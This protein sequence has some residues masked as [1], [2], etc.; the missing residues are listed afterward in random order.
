M[1]NVT[2]GR[3]ANGLHLRGPN[4]VIS[5]GDEGLAG[6]LRLAEYMLRG[7]ECRMVLAGGMGLY[8]GPEIQAPPGGEGRGAIRRMA[9]GTLLLA[10]TLEETARE[11]EFPILATLT[12]VEEAVE[13]THRVGELPVRFLGADGLLELTGA[14]TR[15]TV[16]HISWPTRRG[17]GSTSIR[18]VPRAASSR[19]NVVQAETSVIKEDEIRPPSS[20]SFFYTTT[21]LVDEPAPVHPRTGAKQKLLV[22]TDAET[23]YRHRE[24]LDWGGLPHRTVVCS[25]ATEIPGVLTL[26]PSDKA[27]VERLLDAPDLEGW[28]AVLAVQDHPDGSEE[29]ESPFDRLAAGRELLDLLFLV[30]KHGYQSIGEG[31]CKLGALLLN[32]ECR[33][34]PT[35]GLFAGLLKSLARELPRANVKTVVTDAAD[36]TEALAQMQTEWSTGPAPNRVEWVYQRGPR[37]RVALQ[38]LPALTG[39][40]H[41]WLTPDAVVLATGGGRGVTA[42]LVEALPRRHHCR[43][44]L[45]GRSDPKKVPSHLLSM[46]EAEFEA[47]EALFYKQ[48][49]ERRPGTRITDLK[50]RYQRYRNAREVH[51]TIEVLSDLA[52][53]VTYA[54]VDLLDREAVA[55]AMEAL[56]SRNGRLDLV[57]HGAGIQKSQKL[58]K[59]ELGEFRAIIDTKLVGLANLYREARARSLLRDTHFHLLT[60]VFSFLGNDGQ[61][62]Y[63][64]ANEALNALATQQSMAGGHGRWTSMAWLGWASIGMTRGS[65]YANLAISRNL[66]PVTAAEGQA[67]LLDLLA[68]TPVAAVNL[69]ISKG[70]LDF[71]GARLEEPSPDGARAAADWS[72]DAQNHPFLN[73]H[74][75]YGRPTMPGAFM[76][77]LAVRAALGLRPHMRANL[78]EDIAFLRFAKPPADRPLQ[79]R[80][81][82]E[83]VEET[84]E[85]VLVRVRL[86]SDFIHDSGRI[87][88]KDMIHFQADIRMSRESVAWSAREVQPQKPNEPD[89]YDPYLAA[90]SPVKLD[91]FFR[92]LSEIELSSTGRQAR[93][94]IYDGRKLEALAGMP[95]AAVLLDGLFR[96]SMIHRGSGGGFPIYVPIRCGRIFLAAN[97]N[98]LL[99]YRRG[100]PLLL[101][102]A[103]PHG[104]SEKMANPYVQVTDGDGKL[105]LMVTDLEAK[106]FG[107][108]PHYTK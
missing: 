10:L 13:P 37:R 51:Q 82:A 75:I 67:V 92:C 25:G 79:L 58:V 50:R 4:F 101:S 15:T 88:H 52:G 12:T 60:S 85:E 21:C 100:G 102:G 104:N 34:T 27:S 19:E 91:G 93:F 45:W 108:V 73:D 61:P 8:A 41:A 96:F 28:D 38:R 84:H 3:V 43:V 35:N 39:D 48:E 23:A 59:K 57:L 56:V 24:L 63:G 54:A 6:L 44:I 55:L 9:E 40:R 11:R 30:A 62:D 18:V 95:T 71:Y 87:L 53:E 86:L 32:R 26:N 66:Y 31:R 80:A 106:R 70:E 89:L 20:P 22:L 98:D 33:I 77:D 42:V 90:Q 68:G 94:R 78:L 2:A 72:F 105:I 97:F 16:S 46:S 1:P 65:E 14:L 64:A 5:G 81:Q 76:I 47:Y 49:L 103:N 29:G 17:S 7:G 36:L 99:L 107:E 74:L 83:I 69:L